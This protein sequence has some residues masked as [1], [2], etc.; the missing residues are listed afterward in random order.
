MLSTKLG[1]DNGS[2]LDMNTHFSDLVSPGPAVNS[3]YQSEFFVRTQHTPVHTLHSEEMR[4]SHEY[5]QKQDRGERISI[6]Q[7]S[8][9]TGSPRTRQK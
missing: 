3:Y 1:L 7:S 9:R 4:D 5:K 8:R 6:R 2:E